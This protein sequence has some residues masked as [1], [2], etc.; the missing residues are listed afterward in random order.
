MG[1]RD[2]L[3]VTLNLSEAKNHGCRPHPRGS[4]RRASGFVLT[5]KPE[6]NFPI[7]DDTPGIL[8]SGVQRA[9]QAIMTRTHAP[10]LWHETRPLR[11]S[12]A[13]RRRWHGRSVSGTRHAARS[14]G[15]D[16]SPSFSP[17]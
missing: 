6:V 3:L 13:A 14:R 15:C 2:D 16:Q 1:H 12:I 10:Y 4:V 5:G 8:A 11:D 17:R 7:A 9:A